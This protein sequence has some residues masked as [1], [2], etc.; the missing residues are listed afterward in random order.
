MGISFFLIGQKQISPQT[1][2]KLK[3]FTR[4]RGEDRDVFDE[5]HTGEKSLLGCASKSRSRGVNPK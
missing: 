2:V 4:A 5:G 1:S 3:Y